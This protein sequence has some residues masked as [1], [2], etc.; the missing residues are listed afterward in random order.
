MN[1]LYIITILILTS[2]FTT[3]LIAAEEPNILLIIADDLGVDA[4][5]GYGIGTDLPIT[6]NIDQLRAEGLN[7][8][9]VWA[10]P[11]CAAT[12]ASIMTGKYGLNNGVNTVPGNL[13]TE[14]KSIFKEVEE[15]KP[16]YTNCLIGKWHLSRQNKLEHPTLHGVDDFMGLM[17]NEV[18]S[19]D[20][21]LKV[22]DGSEDTCYTYVTNYLTDYAIDWIGERTQPWLM[23]LAHVSP[24]TPFHT[25]PDSLHTSASDGTPAGKYKTMIEALDHNIGRLLESMSDSVRQNT[26]IFFIGDNGTPGNVMQGFPT[27]HGKQTL[28]Q[29]GINVPLIASGYGV[30]RIGE[31]EDAMINISDLYPTIAQLVDDTAYPSGKVNDGQSFKSFLSGTDGEQRT[32][33]YMEIGANSTID[34]TQ[35]TTRNAQYK[36]ID[37]GDDSFEMYDLQADPLEETDLLE[38]SLSTEQQEAKTELNDVMNEILGRTSDTTITTPA[39]TQTGSY[40]IVHTGVTEFANASSLISDPGTTEALHWQDA[41]RVINSPSYTDNGDGTVTDNITQLMWQ[42]DM[43]DKMSYAEALAA[44]ATANDTQLNGYDDWRIPT[45]KELYSLILFTGRVYGE[46]AETHFIDTDYFNQPIGDTAID[47]REIDAQTW[48][49]THYTGVTMNSDTTVFG[50]NF[51]DG[52]IKGYPKYKKQTATDNTMYFR[53]VRGN[54]AYG[55]NAFNDNGDGTVTD[56]ATSLMWQQADDGLARDW[57]SSIEYCEDLV[58]GNY[59]DWHLPNAKE[60]H[61]IVD[62]SRSPSATNS[63]AIDAV[64]ATT[65]I[66]DAEGNAGHY[67][68][69]WSTSPHKDGNSPYACAVYIAFGKANGQMNSTLMDVHGAGAQRSDPKAGDADDYPAYHGPQ[70]DVQRVYNHC[71]CVR[72]ADSTTPTDELTQDKTGFAVYPNP[73]SEDFTIVISTLQA[74]STLSV[75]DVSGKLILQQAIYS[76][77]TSIRGD[78]FAKGMYIFKVSG[79]DNTSSVKKVVKY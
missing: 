51:V 67:P 22:E 77:T 17:G 28:Y 72:Q 68:Y 75:Y 13:S 35:Y 43:G 21:W 5:N 24:H 38:S 74:S 73:S 25:A 49:S 70:G 53:L 3:Q 1:K 15:L 10:T 29:G 4:I 26:I 12:R 32:T 58:L 34:Y 7:F 62:Y 39:P 40:A 18:T 61:S 76:P 8:T 48:S 63:P 47:E 31:T 79:E 60:L 30:T 52:R 23:W 36:L 2:L 9:N 59:D 55:I 65:S 45:I 71:R 11:V 54:E 33:N 41:G 44:V 50:V 46:T 64:F 57:V 37:K 56:S 42:Q 16:N 78:A 6:P 66:T 20:E 69:F 14:H 19:Y 27:G